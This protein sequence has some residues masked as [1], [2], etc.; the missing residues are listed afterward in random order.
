MKMFLIV[1]DVGFDKD[2]TETLSACGVTGYTKWDRVLGKGERS[3]PKMDDA[4]WPGFN[5]AL[6]MAVDRAIE[7][8]VFNGLQSLHKRMGGKELKV[9][10]WPLEK[11]I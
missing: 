6:M 7:P 4:V 10:E 11:V 2:V 8:A 5:C 1:Y 9:F 3:D